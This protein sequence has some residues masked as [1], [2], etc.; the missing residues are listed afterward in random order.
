MAAERQGESTSYRRK[1]SRFLVIS[2]ANEDWHGGFGASCDYLKLV[3]QQ[4]VGSATGWIGGG[5]MKSWA[6]RS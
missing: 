4:L 1:L 3:N 2:E 5:A 6:T